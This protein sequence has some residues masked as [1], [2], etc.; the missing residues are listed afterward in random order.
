MTI[1]DHR[2]NPITSEGT[3]API[4]FAELGRTGLNRF[5]GF[6]REEWHRDLH[7]RHAARIYREMSD[8][9]PIIGA[10]FLSIELLIRQVQKRVD[11]KPG[12]DTPLHIEAQE[13]CQSAIEDVQGGENGVMGNALVMLR[14]G[15]AWLEKVFKISRG[16]SELGI[17]NS[18][19]NDGKIRW[20]KLAPRAPES[21][22][23]WV[24]D[25]A[26][27]VVAMIQRAKPDNQQRTIPR[28]K[29]VHFRLL[30]D[31]KNNPEGRALLRNAYTSYFFQKNIMFT[32]A[33]GI[34]R[35]MAGFP[36]IQLPPSLM[37]SKN[38]DHIAAVRSYETMG[39]KTRSDEYACW[40]TPSEEDVNGK[41]GYKFGLISSSGRNVA[42]TD[43]IIKRYASWV[44]ISLLAKFMLL[45]V[46][47]S[48]SFAL[49]DS[50]TDFFALAV[51]AVL[52]T[53]QAPFTD[54]L[55]PELC[56][57]NGIPREF[58][59][60]Y[61]HGDIEK[62]DM[63]ALSTA[64]NSLTGSGA[65]Q[66]D[67]DLEDHIREEMNLPPADRTEPTEPL[68]VPPAVDITAIATEAAKMAQAMIAK[69]NGTG[70]GSGVAL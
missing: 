13:L 53:I 58:A 34:E 47:K 21:L 65:L 11:L 49:A 22:W 6:V 54:E 7:G 35:Q 26:G 12:A 25:D 31:G 52:D 30:D 1:L 46:D 45:G 63:A 10:V 19:F 56:E 51:A 2:G 5:G 59:P 3:A 37:D 28:A 68:P 20:N 27:E 16:H 67:E 61:A 66:P 38:P 40:V 70:A 15:W 43:P 44:A 64:I 29:S 50:D 24:F 60:V 14:F 18:K 57:L 9:H 39:Q 33:V 69:G 42:Q 41:T 17:F 23:Q 48:G 4:A 62:I 32:E 55:F 8:N 36:H